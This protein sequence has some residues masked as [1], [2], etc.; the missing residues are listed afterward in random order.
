MP[1]EEEEENSNWR[2]EL[3]SRDAFFMD[4]LIFHICFLFIM[5]FY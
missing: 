5:C 1:R 2:E 3:G 4:T